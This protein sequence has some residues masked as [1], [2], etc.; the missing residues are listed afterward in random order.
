MYD[1]ARDRDRIR[2]SHRFPDPP[3]RGRHRRVLP[4]GTFDRRDGD[5][6]WR[7][8]RCCLQESR[9]DHLRL[10]APWADIDFV[11]R[12]HTTTAAVPPMYSASRTRPAVLAIYLRVARTDR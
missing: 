11:I 6:R 8:D 7:S 9:G 3:R 10:A 12:W 1:R 4:T 2:I 5:L